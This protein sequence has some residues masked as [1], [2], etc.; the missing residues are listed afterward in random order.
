MSF[1]L[2]GVNH[3]KCAS[4]LVLVA[5]TIPIHTLRVSSGLALIVSF[6]VESF[7]FLCCTLLGLDISISFSTPL[8]L[9]WNKA[10]SNIICW[11]VYTIHSVDTI[12]IFHS[13]IR[14][15]LRL[16]SRLRYGW[17]LARPDPNWSGWESKS[18]PNK[19]G[20]GYLNSVTK[21]LKPCYTRRGIIYFRIWF[22][23]RLVRWFVRTTFR[24]GFTRTSRFF[25]L[26]TGSDTSGLLKQQ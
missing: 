11:S 24:L 16:M 9:A 4:A 3:K 7:L 25:L 23:I 1:H 18:R 6:K 22:A 15:Q 19:C 26:V 10:I 21:R 2:R 12:P 14:T 17:P 13:C 8:P 20:K 5:S